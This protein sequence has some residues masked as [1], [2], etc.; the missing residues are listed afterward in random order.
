LIT[1]LLPFSCTQLKASLAP[2]LREEIL[3]GA[4]DEFLSSLPPRIA[5]EAHVLRERANNRHIRSHAPEIMGGPG[6]NL[7]GIIGEVNIGLNGAVNIT[8]DGGG[9]FNGGRR[10]ERKDRTGHVKV[11]KDRKCIV[12][13]PENVLKEY[14]PIIT[15]SS[16]KSLVSL[17]YLMNPI[18]PHRLLHKLFENLC[19]NQETLKIIL[20]ILVSIVNDDVQ[21]TSK[22]V[23]RLPYS[24]TTKD[25]KSSISNDFPPSSLL[26]VAPELHDSDI[27]TPNGI[28]LFRRNGNATAAAAA[29]N[30]PSSGRGMT[31][32]SVPPIVARRIMDTLFYL[33]RSVARTC[34]EILAGG[35]DNFLDGYR[36]L[37]RLL[38][39]LS[40]PLYYKSP[41]SLEQLL[42]VLESAVA[43]LSSL[44]K[45][46]E[47]PMEVSQK[48]LDAASA[49]K[50]EWIGVPC[51]IVSQKRLESL[52]SVL[53]L[54][55]CKDS[56]F[57]KVN[58][59]ARRLCRVK[60]NR[61][62]ILHELASVA[63]GLGT[64]ALRDIKALQIQLNEAARKYQHMSVQKEH[65]SR[66]IPA[67]AV[68]LSSS[69]SEI[70]LLRVLQTLH[71]LCGDFD[72]NNKK[73]DGGISQEL[74]NLF[75]NID[76][77]S[78]WFELT[79][80]LRLVHILEGVSGDVDEK[81][82]EGDMEDVDITNQNK[83]L[84][85]N[86]AGLLTRFLPMVESFFVVNSNLIVTEKE[87]D[88]SDLKVSVLNKISKVPPKL[89]GRAYLI[90]FVSTNKVLLNA[91][92]RQNNTLLEKNL[93]SLVRI[94]ECRPFLDFDVKRT[95]FKMQVR[96][97]KK[98]V[99]IR[100]L[101]LSIRRSNVFE[102]SYEQ[103]RFCNV[104]EMRGR[105]HITFR[106]EEGVDAGGL[107]REWFEILAKDMFNPNYALFTS[108]EDGCT[109]QPNHN[110]KINPE[111]LSYFR[112]VGR[113]VGKA[114]LDGYFLDAHFTRS[115]Y[116][117]MLGEKVTHHD[118]EA[119]DPDYYKN[120]KM[121]L[122]YP[123]EDLG[124]DLTFST[125]DHS[126]GWSE[127]LDLIPNGRNIAVTEANK[128]KYVGL[129]CNYR[130]TTAIQEQIKA[131]LEGFHELVKPELVSIFN[132]KELELLI[133]GMPEIDIHDLQRNTEYQNYKPADPQIEWFWNILHSFNRSEKAAFLQFV[134]GSSK[135]PLD[136]FSNLQGMRGTQKFSIHRAGGP[137][138]ALSSA[139]T[140]FN[141]LDLPAY[142][143][144]KEMKEKLLLSINEGR[145][146]FLFA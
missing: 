118:M 36:C 117:H 46:G 38:D 17:L 104:N 134:T 29:A 127:T 145:G 120:L 146:G 116:K 98:S 43:P 63:Q 80:C 83:K 25:N 124:L 76:L 138:T 81:Y 119:I 86:V 77:H 21:G 42:T 48:D 115:L 8:T 133:S 12:Y 32:G 33:S 110:S 16:V 97:L 70:K 113:I 62:N 137:T 79:S 129:V 140:C 39:L 26:G 35:N 58:I 2:A 41:S 106:N 87:T 40:L 18:R 11:D 1:H 143:S 82:D 108:T 67:S 69:S 50:K 31:D 88:N 22:I 19:S 92:I 3:A 99:Q 125:E 5:A 6:G 68:T 111:H 135:V 102:E 28:N 15:A 65:K 47:T 95:W 60:A 10:R 103:L 57:Q 93:K 66:L 13:M 59:V 121:I 112:F 114:V 30:L 64:D 71:T 34:L 24:F 122:E 96:R 55:S 128:E 75:N 52:C 73:S 78:L 91:L 51:P 139:H 100:S 105:L 101:R 85:N 126:F 132:A 136:G 142:T 74:N 123:L 45:D 130:M 131:Y 20:A 54:E 53:R 49:A 56:S 141:A 144:E 89:F 44:P 109:F 9:V 61:A 37:D 7:N 84:D 23:Q 90:H 27:S 72:D 4:D 14:G 107:T 94:H